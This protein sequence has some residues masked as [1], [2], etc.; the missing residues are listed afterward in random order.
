MGRPADLI[1]QLEPDAVIVHGMGP[2]ALSIFQQAKI[3]VLKANSNLVRE[4]L[5]SYVKDE[6]EELTEGCHQARHQY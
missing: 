2:R 3:A 6:F 5:P 1:L 4:L